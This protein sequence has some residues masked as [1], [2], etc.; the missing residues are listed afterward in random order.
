MLMK[1][2]KTQHALCTLIFD[3]HKV[4]ISKNVLLN[5]DN[6]LCTHIFFFFHKDMKVTNSTSVVQQIMKEGNCNYPQN[7]GLLI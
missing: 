6:A 3:P 4:I 5:F 1:E 7:F 2:G